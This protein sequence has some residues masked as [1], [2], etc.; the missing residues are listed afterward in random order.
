MG[1]RLKAVA[2]SV[3]LVF[4]SSHHSSAQ[5]RPDL[6]D[7]PRWRG[8]AFDGTATTGAA[9]FSKPFELRVRWRTTLG[10]GYSGVV[11]AGGHAVTMFSD[12]RSDFLVSLAAETG[13]EEWRLAMGQAFPGRDGSAGGPVSTPALDD[14]VAYAV[15]PRGDLAAVRLAD[16]Q[17]IWKRHLVRDFGAEEPHWGFT[18]SPLVAGNL[19]IVMAGGSSGRAVVGLDKRTGATV[20]QSGSDTVSYQSPMLARI[21]S[22]DQ[23]V[24][25]GDRLLRG[26]DPLDGRELWNHEHGGGGFYARII[27]PVAID[28]RLLLTSKPDASV[29]LD[30]GAAAP[31]AVVWTTRD[32]KLSYSTPVA[33]RDLI[34]GYSGAFLSAIDAGTGALKWRSRAPGDGFVIVVDGHLVVLTK[35]GR[36]AVAEASAAGF[37][38]K[39]SLELFSRL[40]WTPPSFAAGRVYARDSYEEIAAVDVVPTGRT[41]TPSPAP[42]LSRGTVPASRFAEWVRGVERSADPA[43]AVKTF[44]DAQRSFP[45]VEGERLAH[46]LYAGDGRDMSIRSDA[47]ATG[48]E[49]ALHR[50]GSTDLYYASI[51]LEPDARISYQFVRGGEA[52]ADPRNPLKAKSQ[53]FGGDVSLLLMP[54]ADRSLP[55][56]APL[57]GRLVDLEFDGGSATASH[58]TWVGRREVHVYLPPGYDMDTTRRYPVVYVMYGNEMLRDGYLAAAVDAEAGKTIRPAILVFVQNTSGYEYARTFRE[59]HA[60]MMADRLVPWID[61]RYRT[62][63]APNGRAIAG[64]DE[65]GY[66]AVEIGV[67]FPAVFGTVIAQS[68]FPLSGGD[69]ELLALIDAAPKTAQRFYVDWGR[70]DPR[71]AADKLD[72]PGFSAR[73]HDRL[74]ARGFTVSGGATGDGS[75]LVFWSDRVLTALRALF[76]ASPA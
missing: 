32:L 2:V 12:G 41:T 45:I 10:P 26:L 44:L 39:G 70:Y 28:G 42:D 15:G 59:P 76:S 71:R 4:I 51:E 64:A 62:E 16:G 6:R 37:E 53:N 67:R 27:N 20:W 36:L 22:V 75:T 65:A 74:A 7:W 47:M 73:V 18:T 57:R 24:A 43:A 21:G 14:G 60:R 40:V 33:Y 50:V 34:F 52:L 56:A 5:P 58:L 3:A 30:A 66:A 72:V 63:P 61:A 68:L 1:P 23:I 55:A 35:E 8:A 17:S 69:A 25:G 46:I 54:R 38:A 13:R 31:A 49:W 48:S 19:V 11:V 29:L 9:I